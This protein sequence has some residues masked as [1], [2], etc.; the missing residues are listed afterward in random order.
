MLFSLS[1]STS[2]ISM[3]GQFAESWA[4]I[5]FVSVVAIVLPLM[6]IASYH[7]I[8]HTIRQ[9]AITIRTNYLRIG[10]IAKK[11]GKTWQIKILKIISISLL[12][13]GEL[14]DIFSRPTESTTKQKH[15]NNDRSI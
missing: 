4:R 6:L 15:E 14:V 2:Q 8:I 3:L 1:L 12:S 5:V 13:H 10:K 7:L 11:P 9:P